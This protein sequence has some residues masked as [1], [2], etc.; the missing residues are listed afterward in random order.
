MESADLDL[1]GLQVMLRLHKKD[2]A[3]MHLQDGLFAL[4]KRLID[5]I[6]ATTIHL[7]EDMGLLNTVEGL[8]Q[9]QDQNA[10]CQYGKLWP[11]L[12]PV[13]F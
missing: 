3:Q 6:N 1:P 10:R 5:I 4:I 9:G 13:H 8:F 11:K 2:V 7:S 12:S